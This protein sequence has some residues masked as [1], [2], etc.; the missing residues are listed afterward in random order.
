MP[1]AEITDLLRNNITFPRARGKQM[2]TQSVITEITDLLGDNVTEREEKQAINWLELSDS[3]K[4]IVLEQAK[5]FLHQ[6][7][8]EAKLSKQVIIVLTKHGLI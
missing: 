3:Q 6:Q 2:E 4:A 7:M 8:E 1:V 5:T